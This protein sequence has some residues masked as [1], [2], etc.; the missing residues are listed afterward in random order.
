VLLLALL[1]LVL[2]MYS[3]SLWVLLANNNLLRPL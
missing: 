2:Y 3:A 1:C